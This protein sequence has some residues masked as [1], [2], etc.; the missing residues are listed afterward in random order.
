[1]KFV[2]QNTT[3]A[4]G[5]NLTLIETSRG[6][7]S[8]L[9]K[10]G[11]HG[12]LFPN[13][14]RVIICGPSGC[15]K[16]NALLSLLLDPHGLKFENIYIYSKT[17]EQPKYQLLQNVCHAVKDLG[18]H[19]FHDNS[20]VI[21]PNEAKLNSVI[22]FDDVSCEKQ[23]N[24]RL[25]FTLG[26]HRSIDC[27]YLGQTYS[28]IPKQLIR[29]NT[30]MLILF[31]QDDLNL[32]HVYDDHVAADMSWNVFKQMCHSCW[33]FEKYSFLLIDNESDNVNGGRYRRGFDVFIQL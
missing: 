17:L 21:A 33:N 9:K 4:V 22:I 28:K 32:R 29:D 15:G 20:D 14:M 25:Y 8:S 6:D 26:R 19:T 1:M 30:N 24:I 23:D 11:K 3:L 10:T 18:Y 5:D 12:A 16:T 13:N 2:K 27:F 31:K 7:H